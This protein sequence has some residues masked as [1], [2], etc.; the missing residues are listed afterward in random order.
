MNEQLDLLYVTI[1]GALICMIVE[2]L[3]NKFLADPP[4]AE[5]PAPC[6]DLAGLSPQ[7]SYDLWRR[8]LT[9]WTNCDGT[10]EGLEEMLERWR[11]IPHS[12]PK[13][14]IVVDLAK[15]KDE[16]V[17]AKLGV[18]GDNWVWWYEKAKELQ[19]LSD[20]L[21]PR[22]DAAKFKVGQWVRWNGEL[23]CV[24]AFSA[25]PDLVICQGR[26]RAIRIAEASLE[27]AVP[28]KGEWW[29]KTKCFDP[30]HYSDPGP[31]IAEGWSDSHS[32][33][34][35]MARHGCLSPFNFGRGEEGKG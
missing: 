26:D 16:T 15:D 24:C 29:T 31:Q 30:S 21:Y 13:Q 20:R 8:E 4:K 35:A 33:G 1:V 28:R 5:D 17:V 18:Q 3:L 32:P 6:E 23:F 7:E 2:A 14:V 9:E 10:S 25:D 19:T 12:K 11:D 27:Q 22:G 34:W